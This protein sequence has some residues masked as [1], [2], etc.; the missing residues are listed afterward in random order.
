MSKVNQLM[1]DGSGKMVGRFKTLTVNLQLE[2]VPTGKSGNN[3][4]HRVVANDVEIGAAW[5]KPLQSGE[6]FYSLTMDDPSFPQ[7]LNVAAFP[8]SEPGEAGVYNIRWN[9]PRQQDAA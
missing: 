7:P 2:L 5:E 6:L 4:S 3:P 1:R 8:S 9:R